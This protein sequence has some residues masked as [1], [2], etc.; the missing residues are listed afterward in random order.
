MLVS[1]GL[2][3][4]SAYIRGGAIFLI[5]QY[6]RLDHLYTLN[7]MKVNCYIKFFKIDKIYRKIPNVSPG[8][9]EVRRPLLGGLY[10]RGAYIWGS[11]Y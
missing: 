10:S 7:Q 2:L 6:L 1:R 11:L 8:L 5:L 9:I 3:F 4:G